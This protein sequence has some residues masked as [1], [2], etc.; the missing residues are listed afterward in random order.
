MAAAVGAA[1]YV[2]TGVPLPSTNVR[3]GPTRRK[4]V[5]DARDA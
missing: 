5:T 1:P 4:L 2:N 3:L